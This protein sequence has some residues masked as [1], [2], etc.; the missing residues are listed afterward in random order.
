MRKREQMLLGDWSDC[1]SDQL[2]SCHVHCRR[3]ALLPDE[4]TEARDQCR[5]TSSIGIHT[6]H[7]EV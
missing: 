6:S 5:L 4:L 3:K 1:G 2:E 7:L